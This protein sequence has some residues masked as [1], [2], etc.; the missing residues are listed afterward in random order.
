MKGIQC[1]A[2]FARR[3]VEPSARRIVSPL[4]IVRFECPFRYISHIK[5]MHVEAIPSKFDPEFVYQKLLYVISS[6]NISH[7]LNS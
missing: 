2:R 7:L 3:K 5:L 6:L 1:S 4:S